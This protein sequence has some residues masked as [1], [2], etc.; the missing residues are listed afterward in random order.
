M[1]F[2]E[3]LKKRYLTDTK[4]SNQEAEKM[5]DFSGTFLTGLVIVT[6]AFTVPYA[7]IMAARFN[8]FADRTGKQ[9][10]AER[11]ANREPLRF[12]L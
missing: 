6:M 8:F 4:S 10:E 11:T 7:V 3:Y 12:S 1:S 5:A 9:I 2:Y